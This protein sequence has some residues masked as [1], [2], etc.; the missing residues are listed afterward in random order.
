[1][2]LVGWLVYHTDG[3]TC[4]FNAELRSLADV[5]KYAAEKHGSYDEVYVKK[6]VDIALA[7][8]KG[9]YEAFKFVESKLT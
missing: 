8:A 7:Q 9:E 3:T 2:N 1:M 4:I 6:D 5:Q